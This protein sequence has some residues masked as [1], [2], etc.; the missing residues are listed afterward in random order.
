MLDK[1]LD[2]KELIN[3]EVER[4]KLLFI[5]NNYDEEQKKWFIEAKKKS[6]IE[7]NDEKLLY[8]CNILEECDTNA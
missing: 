4:I 6:A 2:D 8:V 1:L 7:N 3:L 5:K